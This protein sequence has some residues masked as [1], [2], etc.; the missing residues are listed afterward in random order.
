MQT[1]AE[2]KEYIKLCSEDLQFF[3]KQ[4]LPHLLTHSI[5]PFHAELYNLV[6][7][8]DYLVVAAP[9]GF[10][11]STI[12]SVIYPIWLG[13]TA[14]R[15][16]VVIIS[17]SESLAIDQ[18]RKIKREFET[19]DKLKKFFG[20]L[21]TDKWS[22]SHII[23]KTGVSIR[24]R[25]AEGQIRGF[26]PDCLIIDDLETDESV[27]SDER[28]KKL[29]DWFYKACLNTLAL[30]GQLLLIGTILHPRSLLREVLSTPSNWTKRLFRAYRSDEQKE[31]NELWPEYW[32]HNRLQE[33]KAVIGSFRFSSEFLNMPQADE[34]API[35]EEQIRY[36]TDIPAQHSMVIAVD[37]AYSDDANA[38]YKT[39][40]L[41]AMDDKS[42]RYLV[43]YI[44]THAPLGEYIDSIL[45]LWQANKGVVTAVGVPNSGVEKSFYNSFLKRA[46]ER[47]L[48]PPMQELSNSFATETGGSKRGKKARVTAALQPLFE[49]GKYYINASHV[50]AKD[51]LL[52]F[53]YSKHDDIVDTLA[54]AEQILQ[55]AFYSQGAEGDETPP[56]PV[57]NYGVIY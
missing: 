9:R 28:R 33:R 1:Q 35:K 48:Y 38:D 17:A 36:Y 40:S 32:P 44:R 14:R 19:N 26:R 45:N 55:P 21:Q 52:S 56:N 8:N 11:K 16:E 31:G 10:A 49:Q 34:S 3:A 13:I 50:E 57:E 24:A 43:H 27:E 20:E 46:S 5:P 51:E 2:V 39:A 23:L 25:G 7:G 41:V 6:T 12:I 37:P 54:Y 18:V 47:N 42:N 53:M 29:A 15:S 30:N 4:F 22:E